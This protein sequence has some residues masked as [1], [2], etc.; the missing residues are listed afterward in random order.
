MTNKKDDLALIN[1]KCDRELAEQFKK[2][3]KEQG[4]SQSLVLRELMKEYLKKN[5]EIEPLDN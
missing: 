5:A 4:Y 2:A 1:F 3:T